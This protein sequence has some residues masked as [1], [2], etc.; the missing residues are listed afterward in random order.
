MCPLIIHAGDFVFQ[1]R[2]EEQLAP[3][4]CAVRHSMS[5]G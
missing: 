1:A 3:K 2:F 5:I 4:T